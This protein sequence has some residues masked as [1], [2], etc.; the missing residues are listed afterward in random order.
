MGRSAMI[1]MWIDD[2]KLEE[3]V[4]NAARSWTGDMLYLFLM[5]CPMVQKHYHVI[6][7]WIEPFKYTWALLSHHYSP[8]PSFR[9]STFVYFPIHLTFSQFCL[10]SLHFN[11]T[12]LDA[13]HF[14]K[15]PRNII[16]SYF[17]LIICK[18]YKLLPTFVVQHKKAIDKSMSKCQ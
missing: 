2:G 18:S 17:Y 1:N 16:L 10:L 7:V 14:T 13:F 15:F 5:Q 6:G 9:F 4:S 11:F 3:P 8:Q 12:F